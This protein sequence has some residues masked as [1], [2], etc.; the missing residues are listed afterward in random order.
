MSQEGSPVVVDE[1]ARIKY[2]KKRRRKEEKR[3]ERKRKRLGDLEATTVNG[4][5]ADVGEAD[6]GEGKSEVEGDAGDVPLANGVTQHISPIPIIRKNPFVLNAL[7]EHTGNG[8]VNG[9]E[10]PTTPPPRPSTDRK[11]V[12]FHDSES[13]DSEYT[14]KRNRKGL[15]ISSRTDSISKPSIASSKKVSKRD[16]LLNR[17]RELQEQR[18]KLPIWTGTLLC[19]MRLI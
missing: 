15:K 7:A 18:E 8:P 11:V 1:S 4:N 12:Q 14:P 5:S 9:T 3:K 17:K 13:S 2:S 19:A 16:E 6:N 10:G